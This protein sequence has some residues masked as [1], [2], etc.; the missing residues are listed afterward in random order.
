MAASQPR[1]LPLDLDDPP[2]LAGQLLAGPR[3]GEVAPPA[4]DLGL[5]QDGHQAGEVGRREG[6]QHEP[7]PVE[8]GC[9]VHR[10]NGRC[11]TRRRM[12][13]GTAPSGGILDGVRE[14]FEASTDFTVG[15]EE[16]YQLL[17]PAD[18]RARRAA[19]RT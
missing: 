6:P 7:L 18:P 4:G 10:H 9:R 12:S 8:D 5:G 17:D 3:L 16:E 14:R 15:I 19:S 11:Y 13:D 1:D 2:G